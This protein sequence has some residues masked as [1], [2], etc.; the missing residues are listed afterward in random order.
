MR[1]EMPWHIEL[2]SIIDPIFLCVEV[3]CSAVKWTE[4]FAQQINDSE[5]YLYLLLLHHNT[6]NHTACQSGQGDSGRETGP[7]FY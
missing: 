1:Y 6:T 5:S 3:N 7:G 2:L 4:V